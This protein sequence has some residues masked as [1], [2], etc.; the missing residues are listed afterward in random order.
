MLSPVDASLPVDHTGGMGSGSRNGTRS[1]GSD[2]RLRASQPGQ[3]HRKRHDRS[4]G[5]GEHQEASAREGEGP[6]VVTPRSPAA[7]D[8]VDSP[9]GEIVPLC[10][11]HAEQANTPEDPPQP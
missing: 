5:A 1:S 4:R 11:A 6:A 9:P 2:E 10:A 8:V 7:A 3:A